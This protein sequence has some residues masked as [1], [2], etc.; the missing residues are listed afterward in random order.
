MLSIAADDMLTFY[1]AEVRSLSCMSPYVIMHLVTLCKRLL[2]SRTTFPF[3]AVHWLKRGQWCVLVRIRVVKFFFEFLSLPCHFQYG[4]HERELWGRQGCQIHYH[5][6]TSHIFASTTP[7]YRPHLHDQIAAVIV[8]RTKGEMTWM[9][10]LTPCAQRYLRSTCVDWNRLSQLSLF[11]VVP[12]FFFLKKKLIWPY[13][14]GVTHD[15]W[16]TRSWSLLLF[17]LNQSFDQLF[18]R[19]LIK[20]ASFRSHCFKLTIGRQNWCRKIA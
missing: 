19:H 20:I 13:L 7:H 12:R 3:A 15:D 16:L 8:L 10:T 4:H 11:K 14:T 6:L 18:T 17:K 1:S 9:G 5:N 2:V